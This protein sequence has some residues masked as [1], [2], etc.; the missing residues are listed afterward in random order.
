MSIIRKIR[1]GLD[2]QLDAWDARLD[3]W[4]AQLEHGRD[5]AME[6]L[7]AGRKRL[8]DASQRVEEQLED[9]ADLSAEAAQDIR[10][11]LEALR[12]QLALGEAETRDAY[13]EQ[14]KKL[15]HA[16]SEAE[17]KLAVIEHRAEDRLAGEMERFVKAADRLQAEFEAAELQF[18]LAKAEARDALGEK[19]EELRSRLGKL[20][21]RLRAARGRAG[22]RL[23]DLE[24]ELTEGVGAYREAVF[25]FYR[26]V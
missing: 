13:R 5:E 8:A 4:E 26:H 21:E 23:E 1:S 6:R 12:V 2:N 22:D 19:R 10:E 9:A 18:A 16:L 20:R 25:G 11:D 3:A 7:A 24:E 15:R 17:A 14:R